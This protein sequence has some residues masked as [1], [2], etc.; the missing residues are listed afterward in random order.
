MFKKIILSISFLFL[1]ITVKA[2][3]L[4]NNNFNDIDNSNFK[5]AISYLKQNKIVKGYSNNNF[6]PQEKINRVEF[7]KIILESSSDFNLEEAKNIKET[8]NM[9]FKD[10]NKNSWYYPY[11]KFA[12]K[13]NIIK[14]Y[15]D[16]TF[17][18]LNK[19]NLPE[20]AKILVLTQNL[21]TDKNL[22][23]NQV[24]YKKYLQ[25]LTKK[26]LVPTT[27]KGVNHLISREE[28]AEFI[29]R[30]KENKEKEFVT[31]DDLLGINSL[32]YISS[33]Q[34]LAEK[35]KTEQKKEK[36]LMRNM[37]D[38]VMEDTAT[39]ESSAQIEENS[40]SDYSKTNVQVKGVD[41]ADIVKNDGQYIYL[42]SGKT[43]KIIDTKNNLTELSSVLLSEENENFNPQELFLNGDQLIVIGNSYKK[44][45]PQTNTIKKM[46][47]PPVSSSNLTKVYL[48]DTKNKT[49]P[50][51]KRTISYDANYSKSRRIGDKMYLVLNKRPNYYHILRDKK[52]E[53]LKAED[54]LPQIQDSSK[55]TEKCLCNDIA[56]FPGYKEP[57]YLMVSVIPL[58]DLEKEISKKVILGASD[59]VY[60]SKKALYVATGAKDDN[61]AYWSYDNTQVYK[62]EFDD[63]K[64]NYQATTIVPGKILNQFS[65][66]E[67]QGNFRIATTKGEVWNSKNKSS[68]RLYVYDQDLKLLGSLENIAP[69]ERIY[70]VRFMGERAF[71]VT[72]KTVD[73]LFVIDLKDVKNPQI[74]GELKIPGWSDYLHPYDENH[75]IG[76]GKEVDEDIDADKIHSDNA[77]YYTAVQGVKVSLF[78]VSDLSNPQEKFKWVIGDRGTESEI[79]RE[80]KALFFDKEKN[81]LAFPLTVKEKIEPE[82]LNCTQYRYSTC[83]NECLRRCIPTECKENNDSKVVCTDDCE[84][85]GSCYDPKYDRFETT[86]SGAMFLNISL[87]EGIKERGRISSSLKED[88]EKNN[89]TYQ[90]RIRRIISI[91]ENLY[92]ISENLIKKADITDIK[93]KDVLDF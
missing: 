7:L 80:H 86:F 89:Y 92:T 90:D 41:E 53:D 27:I 68:N 33:C 25:T 26:K 84:G 83:P 55:N 24:W 42:I 2:Q 8:N 18:P 71:M 54:L 72:F 82:T 20:M 79:L 76:F 59:N 47:Y 29:Y 10:I 37:F 87:D 9:N 91:G 52:E 48:I 64:I 5:E 45:E 49:N 17:K 44:Y 43:I 56:Y 11:L 78:D 60:M 35:I 6:K 57:N 38:G 34:D 93:I 23:E 39:L 13:N 40:D 14:G 85:L 62:F 77:V 67:Y 61:S 15:E 12:V 69:G 3:I 1:V 74:L 66:D 28:M 4:D 81:L 46:I 19:I 88:E 73:P 21:E 30:L 51:I 36:S 31:Y 16:N 63:L 65:M 50:E 70:S 32:K 22:D 58:D 75:L